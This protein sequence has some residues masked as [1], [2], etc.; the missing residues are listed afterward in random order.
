MKRHEVSVIKIEWLI[1][2]VPSAARRLTLHGRWL[3]RLASVCSRYNPCVD[4]GRGFLR[5][6][7]SERHQDAQHLFL[8]QIWHFEEQIQ[9][10]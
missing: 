2:M 9:H 1:Y 3:Q 10:L 4:K 6:H 5:L 8:V 7:Y